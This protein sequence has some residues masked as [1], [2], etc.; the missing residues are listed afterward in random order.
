MKQFIKESGFAIGA[1]AAIAIAGFGIVAYNLGMQWF[2]AP[3]FENVRRQTYENSQ[4]Y[5]DGMVQQLQLIY[6]EYKKSDKEGKEIIRSIVSRQYAN[7]PQER[8]PGHLR[9]FV[10]S[11]LNPTVP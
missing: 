1:A 4:S 9:A 2:F 11:T 10:S 7:F 8:L 6:L 5:N 3:K